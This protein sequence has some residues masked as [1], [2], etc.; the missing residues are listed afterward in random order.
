MSL[1]N[2]CPNTCSSFVQEDFFTSG[3][4]CDPIICKMNTTHCFFFKRQKRTTF[5]SADVAGTA[6]HYLLPIRAS[7]G[8][9][10]NQCVWQLLLCEK[11]GSTT[12]WRQVEQSQTPGVTSFTVLLGSPMPWKLDINF[13]QCKRNTI[14]VEIAQRRAN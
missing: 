3:K 14:I 1:Y 6:E 9:C 8:W 5:R 4:Q 10:R 13:S 12:G 2:F 11:G 7:C